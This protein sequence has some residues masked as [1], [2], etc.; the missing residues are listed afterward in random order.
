M[1]NLQKCISNY[2]YI[3][4]YLLLSTTCVKRNETKYPFENMN[5]DQL[6]L[7][8][9]WAGAQNSDNSIIRTNQSFYAS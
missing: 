8:G 4:I 6:R 3:S 1:M 7:S 5:T 9:Y 2:A